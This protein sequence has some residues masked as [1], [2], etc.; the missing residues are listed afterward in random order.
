AEPADTA[1]PIEAPP[2]APCTRRPPRGREL[3]RHCAELVRTRTHSGRCCLEDPRAARPHHSAG[4][5]RPRVDARGLSR[6]AA[7][8]PAQTRI[9]PRVAKTHTPIFT[10]PLRPGASPS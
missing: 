1:T 7:I 10:I 9:A 8:S 3:S 4:A 2:R 5:L 6:P